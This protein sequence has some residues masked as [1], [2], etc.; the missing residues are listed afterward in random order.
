MRIITLTTDFGT[1]DPYLSAVKGRIYSQNE[2]VTV[3][4]ISNE[5]QPFNGTEAAYV[6]QNAYKNFPKESIHL[7]G[8]N[9]ESNQLNKHIIVYANQHYFICADNG[10]ISLILGNTTPEWIIQI[11][12]SQTSDNF[13]T[14]DVFVSVVSQLVKHTP[15]ERLGTRIDSFQQ[16]SHLN[17]KI[18]SDGNQIVGNVIYIDNY[19]NIVTSI[20]KSM[21]EDIGSGRQVEIIARSYTFNKVYS[22]YADFTNSKLE[23]GISSFDGERL[24]LFNS[25]GY[26]QISIYKGSKLKGGT[27]FSLLGLYPETTSIIVNFK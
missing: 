13:P 12:N 4:D 2:N 20:T 3:V 21:F 25:A 27:A 9:T 11:P 10:I 18:N 26:L 24:A 1:K 7:I 16:R 8:V 14:L 5:I 19:G 15:I 23:K 17:A 6:L 22:S